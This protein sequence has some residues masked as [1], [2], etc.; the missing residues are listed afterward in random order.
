MSKAAVRWLLLLYVLRS[1]K[2]DE[3]GTTSFQGIWGCGRRI[4]ADGNSPASPPT[5]GPLLLEFLS[6]LA[7]IAR[8]TE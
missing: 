6:A 4:V 8:G 5:W 7:S 3:G 1:S 2:T